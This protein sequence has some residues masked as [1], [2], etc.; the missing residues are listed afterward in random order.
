MLD[1]G[2]IKESD[3]SWASPVVLVP[4]KDNSVRFCADY[5]KLNAVTVP[6][7]YPLP[8]IDDMLDILSKAK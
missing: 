4:K 8:R 2:V 3:S 1:L 6:D 7:A 5:R